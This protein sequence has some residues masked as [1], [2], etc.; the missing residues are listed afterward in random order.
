[1]Q[2]QVDVSAKY[3]HCV[4]RVTHPFAG[5]DATEDGRRGEEGLAVEKCKAVGALVSNL[6][7]VSDR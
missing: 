2:Q 4:W 7:L 3:G 5:E 1:M 6:I